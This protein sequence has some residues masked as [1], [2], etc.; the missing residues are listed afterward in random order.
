MPFF[1]RQAHGWQQTFALVSAGT[2]QPQLAQPAHVAMSLPVTSARV[3][4]PPMARVLRRA[5]RGL[6]R[7]DV[8]V[9]KRD[10]LVFFFPSTV[11]W[12]F[13]V[14]WLLFFL[15]VKARVFFF[16]STNVN[17]YLRTKLV[18]Y[19]AHTTTN[20]DQKFGLY[21]VRFLYLALIFSACAPPTIPS[22]VTRT[23]PLYFGSTQSRLSRLPLM[24]PRASFSSELF[25]ASHS[26]SSP[27]D[28]EHW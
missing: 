6:L 3:R 16:V 11:C 12:L 14:T 5:L 23:I 7:D 18:F 28:N 25:D 22:V 19:F 27:S 1:G 9:C 15:A 26:K 20:I 2:T 24:S 8:L 21:Y 13:V 10:M 17:L 4:P